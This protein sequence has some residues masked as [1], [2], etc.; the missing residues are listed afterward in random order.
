MLTGDA[1]CS[2]IKVGLLAALP[3]VSRRLPPEQLGRWL[4][5]AGR[6][7]QAIG[8]LTILSWLILTLLE[9]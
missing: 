8:I 2:T 5:P 6:L 7:V 3:F 1:D 9:L 4:P